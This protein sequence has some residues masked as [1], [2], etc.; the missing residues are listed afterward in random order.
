MK[1]ELGATAAP[2]VSAGEVVHE[3]LWS[4]L[5]SQCSQTGEKLQVQ[6]EKNKAESS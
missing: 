3:G 1:K 6:S 2:V 4:W 5:A